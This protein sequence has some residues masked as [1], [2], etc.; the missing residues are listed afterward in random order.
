M[1]DTDATVTIGLR[2]STFDRL[3]A[4]TGD[5]D[6]DD[7]DRLATSLHALALCCSESSVDKIS[8]HVAIEPMSK[9]EQILSGTMR[10]SGEH[11]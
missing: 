8:D 2:Y 6:T 10:I 3:P 7:I 11:L 9:H 1:T 4:D 5:P